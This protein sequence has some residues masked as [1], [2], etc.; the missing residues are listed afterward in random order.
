MTS[1]TLPPC[2]AGALV[3]LLLASAAAAQTVIHEHALP[4]PPQAHF[5]HFGTAVA[6]VG[7]VDH[8][9]IDDAAVAVESLDIFSGTYK[10]WVTLYSGRDLRPLFSVAPAVESTVP[11]VHSTQ[12]MTVAGVGDV[13]GDGTPDFAV[14]LPWDDTTGPDRGTV[15]VYSGRTAKV[16]IARFGPSP[17]ARLGAAVDAAGDVNLD[18]VPDIAAGAPGHDS[19]LFT[20]VADAGAVSTISGASGAELHLHQGTV[21]Y[22]RLGAAVEALGDTDADGFLSLAAGAPGANRVV[23]YEPTTIQPPLTILSSS[24]TSWGGAF[25]HALANVGDAN[26][27]GASDLA[28]GDPEWDGPVGF[29]GRVVLCGGKDGALLAQS[30]PY[31]FD[32][33][34]YTAGWA[35]AR[36]D[37]PAGSGAGALAVLGL[38]TGSGSSGSAHVRWILALN[39]TDKLSSS[40]GLG[41]LGSLACAGDVDGNGLGDLWIGSPVAD[42]QGLDSGYVVVKADADLDSTSVGLITTHST[43][44]HGAAVALLDDLD[45]DGHPEMLVG[46]PFEH[47]SGGL[48]AGVARVYSGETVLHEIQGVSLDQA[49]AAVTGLGDLDGDGV[50]DFAVGRP[51]TQNFGVRKGTVTLHSG[52]TSALLWTHYGFTW[53]DR[54]GAALADLGDLDGDGVSDYAIGAPGASFSKPEA[55]R[56]TAYSGATG[57]KLWSADG[58]GSRERFG[59]AVAAVG[60]VDGDGVP[61]VA[62]GAPRASKTIIATYQGRVDVRRGT[63]GGLLYSMH[64]PS[65]AAA[66]GAALAGA[67]DVSLD[68]VPDV[69]VGAP[70]HDGVSIIGEVDDGIAYVRSGAGGAPLWSAFGFYG[71]RF[72]A[73]AA[74]LGDVTNDGVPDFAF[75]APGTPHPDTGNLLGS[76]RAFSGQ[77]LEEHARWY[78]SEERQLFGAALAGRAPSMAGDV[79]LD[80]L[81]DLITGAP[82]LAQWVYLDGG[83]AMA[84]SPRSA[85]TLHYGSGTPGCA[86]PHLLTLRDAAE[87]GVANELRASHVDPGLVPILALAFWPDVAGS[88]ALGLGALMHVAP[89]SLILLEPL[90]SPSGAYLAAPLAISASPTLQG[91]WVYAQLAFLDTTTCA[92][93]P[94]AISSSNGLAILHE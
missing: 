67:G 24:F 26:G 90:P 50:G 38:S 48:E 44:S 68:G 22:G 33:H 57:I 21:L 70:L 42:E 89:A 61:D 80:G 28:I 29:D 36:V 45:G 27:D 79:D 43:R 51:M 66:F 25:G 41:E 6:N 81:G 39:L 40:G 37:D 10:G 17:G 32:F 53:G 16:L 19:F 9:G 13:D 31:L 74:G 91:T 84:L 58:L 54:Y 18:G 64:G 3:P 47:G 34:D 88:D 72:G 69:A 92:A 1:S 7:D 14:G 20:P 2:R 8:D 12:G 5:D 63:D 85:N 35:L 75:G 56:E 30:D 86:G 4:A 82:G 60:D 52:A 83:R 11:A 78:G 59:S 77:D 15:L 62:I 76:V 49:G 55:G 65:L 73:S 93:L 71:E 23:L 46:A 87:P 94:G